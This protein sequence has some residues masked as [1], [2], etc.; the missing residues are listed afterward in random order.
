[1]A[2]RA[3]VRSVD[4]LAAFRNRLIQY[5]EKATAVVDEVNSE[6]RGTQA[7]LEDR[8][9]RYW[10]HQVKVRA[11]ALEEV[12]HEVFGARLSQFKTAG[13]A[14]QMALHRAKRALKEAEAKLRITRAWSRRYHSDV[15]PLGREVE[16]LRTVLVQDLKKGVAH[17]DCLVGHL[18]QYTVPTGANSSVPESDPPVT[19]DDD[20]TKEEERGDAQ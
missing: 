18:D 17:L 20:D 19:T 14:Q 3:Q 7:W 9:K 10:E 16:K 6:V 12:Q 1:M 11:R 15:E 13:D 2:Q 4:S 8:Q 5:V